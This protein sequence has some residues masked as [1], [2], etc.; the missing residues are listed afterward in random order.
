MKDHDLELEKEL[1]RLEN[2]VDKQDKIITQLQKQNS[3]L[4]K[5]L[6]KVIA[7]EKDE[8]YQRYLFSKAETNDLIS[9]VNQLKKKWYCKDCGRGF[10]ILKI[11]PMPGNQKKYYR[12]CNQCDKKTKFKDYKEGVEGITTEILNAVEN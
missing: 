12:H 1:S 8:D 2:V 6:N 9:K 7:I 11:I 3:T 4:Q 5:Q 10:L